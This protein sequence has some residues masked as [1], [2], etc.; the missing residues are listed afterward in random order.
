MPKDRGIISNNFLESLGPNNFSSEVKSNI[1]LKFKETLLTLL[2]KQI[3]TQKIVTVQYCDVYF[4]W[5]H[6][7]KEKKS[8]Y[9]CHMACGILGPRPGIKPKL[10]VVEAES[11]PLG[12]KASP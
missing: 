1:F 3:I 7:F 12:H 11:K 4:L 2:E 10:P 6:I 8:I 5:I 9:I